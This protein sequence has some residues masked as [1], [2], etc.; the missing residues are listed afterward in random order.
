MKQHFVFFYGSTK[1]ISGP[2]SLREDN[3]RLRN[4]IIGFDGIDKNPELVELG[5]KCLNA[6]NPRGGIGETGTL[7]PDNKTIV[8]FSYL[9]NEEFVFKAQAQS[10]RDQCLNESI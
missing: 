8:P 3:I 5:E 9:N 6:V 4:Q 7:Y 1:I 10:A 2:N